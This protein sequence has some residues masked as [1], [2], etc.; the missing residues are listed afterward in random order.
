MPPEPGPAWLRRPAA[1]W[2]ALLLL[3]VLVTAVLRAVHLPAAWMLGPMLAAIALA[4]QRPGLRLPG[5]ST[6]VAQAV[7]GC[8]IARAMSPQLLGTL[9]P[10][11]PLLLGMNLLATLGIMGLGLLAARRQWLPGTAAIW[12]M[13]PGGAS[14]M[15]MLADAYGGDRRLVALMQYLRLLAAALAVIALGTLFGHPSQGSAVMAQPGSAG[16]PWLAPVPLV[17]LLATVALAAASLLAA[18][19]TRRAT[20]VIF[21]PVFGG[22]ALQAAGCVQLAVPPLASVLAFAVIGWHVG[23][24][25]TREALQESARLLPR[26][27]LCIVAILLVCAGLGVLMTLLLPVDLVTAC[28]A[29]NP[30]GMDAVVLM[31]ASIQVD[32]P[33]IL[34]MQVTRLMLVMALG[35]ALGRLAANHHLARTKGT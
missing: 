21:V 23:L 6:L 24:G 20:L 18:W 30:G 13:S 34:A 2:S 28:M 3:T 27:L 9:Q 16:T 26:I 5:G 19:A 15:V 10:H 35:P 14:A 22:M 12:G 29:L 25:F 7:L 33:L 31:A 32:L 8:L 11:W 17:P 4:L 1:A